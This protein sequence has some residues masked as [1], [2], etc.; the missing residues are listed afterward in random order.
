MLY[1]LV[2]PGAGPVRLKDAKAYLKVDNKSDDFV[3][4]SLLLATVQ[5]AEKY[6]GRDFRANS[7]KLLLDGFEDRICLRRSPVASITQVQ[8]TLAGTLTTIAA[9]VYYLKKGPQF[10][11]VLLLD[12]QEWPSDGDDVETTNEHTIEIT[13]ATA[14]PALLEEAR[15]ALLKHLAYLYQNRGDCSS[16]EAARR[17]GATEMYDHFRIARL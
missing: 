5:Y 9:S 17:S 14:V 6:T 3:V 13:F 8:Y 12:E 15:S 10:S 16:E 4:R 1:E 11:E 2:T 7:W